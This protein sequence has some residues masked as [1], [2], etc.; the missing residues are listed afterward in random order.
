MLVN[1]FFRL[2]FKLF[3]LYSAVISLFTILPR[4]ISAIAYQDDWMV[5][6]WTC[7]VV[8]LTIILFLLLAFNSDK[9]VNKLK[10][11]RGFENSHI[12]FEKMDAHTIIKVGCIFLGGLI[13]LENISSLLSHLYIALR[14]GDSSI[15]DERVLGYDHQ[16]NIFELAI[17]I[18]NILISYLLL[19]N[20]AFVSKWLA[21]REEEM[22]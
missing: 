9:I 21:P 8:L 11:S 14:F 18:L 6:V 16:K 10:L 3:A 1:D 4:T 12:P 2:V 20:Y 15:F 5:L 13:F 7:F 22:V 19:T 17:N